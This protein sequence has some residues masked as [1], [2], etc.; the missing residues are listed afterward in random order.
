MEH[1]NKSLIYLFLFFI[2]FFR[3]CNG[4]NNRLKAFI[5]DFNYYVII[6]VD[7]NEDKD[8]PLRSPQ[9]HQEQAS[10]CLTDNKKLF[11]YLHNQT[12]DCLSR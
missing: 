3:L 12:E 2:L 4:L 8:G 9:N 6:D 5:S 1:L 11:E 10:Q 7:V